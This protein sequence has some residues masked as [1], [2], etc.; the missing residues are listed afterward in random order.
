V[1]GC[2]IYDADTPETHPSLPPVAD[3]SITQKEDCV[4]SVLT[5]DCLPILI[6]NRAES[7]VMAVHAGWRGLA[8][9]IVATAV[10]RS[11]EQPNN[12]LVWIGPGIGGQAFE[13]G[14]EVRHAF[15][16]QGAALETH[17]TSLGQDAQGVHKYL[18]DTA[19]IAFWQLKGLGV[20]WMGGG[21]WCTYQ[22][23]DRFFS[24]RRHEK[25]GRMASLIWLA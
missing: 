14:E 11:G 23:E 16:S 12:L 8:D 18:A 19:Q 2:D 13:V 22:E 4:L 25:T 20:G 5:A 3:A 10:K 24:F 9:G 7:L 17:F 21:Q 1:H 6:T 15:L